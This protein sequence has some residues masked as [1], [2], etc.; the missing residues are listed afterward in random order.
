MDQGG[1]DIR[2]RMPRGTLMSE[3]KLV[4]DEI[5]SRIQDIPER[6]DISV[7]IGGGGGFGFGG[8]SSDNATINVALVGKAA[9]DRSSADIARYISRLLRDIPGAEINVEAE[10]SGMGGGAF[11]GGDSVSV[12]IKGAELDT[13]REVSY[14][15]KEIMESIP[16]TRNVTT[17]IDR[18]IP[19]ATIRINRMKAAAFGI[20]A[21]GVAG[22]INTA[23]SGTV[24]TTF[25]VDGEEFDIR[26]TQDPAGLEYL[27][28]LE[29]ILIPSVSGINVPLYEISDIVIEDM[30]VTIQ[31]ENQS[32]YVSVTARLDG[33]TSGEIAA[34]VTALLRNYP[35]PRNYTW[36]LTGTA[37]QMNEAF[38]N[39]GLAL[40]ISLFLI[41]MILA[42][43]FE[44][45]LFPFIV[46]F[47]V[48]L[49][50]TGGLFGLFILGRPLSITG[51]LGLI[52]LAGIVTNN[53][54][55]LIDYTN[56]LV[57]ERGMAILDA[58]K[59]AGPVRLRPILMTTLTSVIGLLPMMF[60]ASE[61]AEM[62][63]GLATVVV[64]G[65]ALSMLVT[66]LF[67]PVVYLMLH[68]LRMRAAGIIR[69]ISHKG[70][71]G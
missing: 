61:G 63:N 39:L 52:M 71:E 38:A 17:S 35:M 12:N 56:L 44:G 43:Q 1:V 5:V 28:D 4:T 42:A 49:A 22:I 6:E 40:I 37:Q 15:I 18:T 13:L 31:R 20:N 14:D 46:M 21:A 16:G 11:G 60:T 65:L 25:K 64:C 51:Y 30:P 2:V 55:V 27:M 67:V 45:F 69:K 48:P 9:R 62:M 33:R 50:L 10:A 19:Q 26:V 8:G 3:T 32:R 70:L 58:L 36:E 47:S 29:S 68:G 24:A 57:R 66:L 34:D 23:I 53:A 41:Y 59:A 7:R 54:I